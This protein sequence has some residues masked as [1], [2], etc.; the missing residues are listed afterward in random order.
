MKFAL[1]GTTI[2]LMSMTS[3]WAQLNWS[4]TYNYNSNTTI[5][6][7]IT[8]T[9]A[10]TVDVASGV[11]VTINGTISAPSGIYY[12]FTK[13]GAGSLI[14]NN[15]TSYYGTT[16]IES[17]T[18]ILGTNGTI[19]S[20][21]GV[22]FNSNTAK[23]DLSSGNKI[24]KG[25]NATSTASNA[26]V[27]IGSNTLTITTSYAD[28]SF[29]GKITGSG[30]IWKDSNGTLT[31]TGSNT[32]TGITHVEQGTLQIGDGVT[33]TTSIIDN[34]SKVAM[35]SSSGHFATI[36]FMPGAATTFSKVISGSNGSMQYEGSSTKTLTLSA[37]N[38]YTGSTTI[39]DG[40]LI[41]GTGGTIASN[42][43]ISFNSNTAK[44]DV[45]SGSKTIRALNAASTVSN[46]EVILGSSTLTIASTINNCSFA[47][48]IIGTGGI[49]KSGSYSLT[50]DGTNTYTGNTVIM[51]GGELIL[52]SNGS[53]S[54]SK[55]S[56]NGS[57]KILGNNTI[58]G[59]AGGGGTSAGVFINS[60]TLTINTT[61]DC[62]YSGPIT[63]TG[64]IIKTGNA[65][66]TLGG[67]STYTGTTTIEA[68]TLILSANGTIASDYGV[69]LNSNSAKLDV[70][71]GNKTIKGLNAASTVSNAEV[72]LGSS[73]L[74][75]QNSTNCSFAGKITG[76]GGITKTGNASLT[77]DGANCGTI[78]VNGGT[79]FLSGSSSISSVVNLSNTAKL[80]ISAGNK[81]IGGLNAT[82]SASSAEVILGSSTLTVS[83][84]SY[85]GK[86]IGTGGVT[87]NGTASFTMYN[88]GNTAT[89]TFT[90]NQ[91]TV[92]LN[93]CKW[94]GNFTTNTGVTLT[95]IGNSTVGPLTLANGTTLTVT[96][97]S[98]IG[99]LTLAG[100]TINFNLN[101][102]SPS[103]LAV[104][105]AVTATGT[106]TI[107][108]ATSVIQSGYTLISAASGITS[109]TPYVLASV[110]GYPSAE[111]FVNSPTLLRF[112]TASPPVITTTTL[113]NGTVGTPYYAQL[114]ATGTSPFF[115]YLSGGGWDPGL[116][117]STTGL[118]SGTP[119][120]AGTINFAVCA[121][122]SIGY[123]QAS[124]SIVIT[125]AAVAPTIT[126]TTLP[127][128]TIG[129]TY[130]QQLEATGTAS[131][132]WTLE[133][134]SLP[135][136]LTL[137]TTGEISGTPTTAGTFD[138][139][140]HASN[141]VG[142]DTKA[143]SITI[144]EPPTIT[145]TT[146]PDGVMGT[147]YNA[148]LAATGTT[149]ITW[150]IENG[151]LP[152]NLSLSTTG[153]ISGTPTATGTFNFTVKAINSAGSDTKALS[154]TI[155]TAAVAPIITT[156]T[157]PN[158]TEGTA[159]NQPL[160]ATGT[161]PITWTVSV[162][163]LP[164]GL[165]LSETGIISGT[166]TTAGTFN[167]TAKATNS[168]G[169]DTKAL[170]IT[171]NAVII[172][173]TITTTTLPDGITGTAYSKTLT[174]TGTTPINWAIANGN[175][176]T[177]L[178]LSTSGTISGTPTTTGTFNFT[179]KATNSAGNDTKALT[180]T[181]GT[182]AIA[183]IITT[184]TLPNGTEG[185]AYNQ[186]LT[187][188]G[189]A[190]ITWSLQ[191]GNLPAGLT[192]SAEGVITGTPTA[193]GTSNFTVKATNSA[194]SDTKVLSIKIESIVGIVETDNEPALRIYPNPTNGE[195]HIGYA[196]CDNA[197]CDIEIYD[198]YGRMLQTISRKSEIGK[199]EIKIDVSHLPSGIY[200][201]RVGN[202][203][204]K[205]VK[206]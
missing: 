97:N 64:G 78:T 179:V 127:N 182:T 77:L 102:S 153:I 6:E 172:P 166:P 139:V 162:G 174:A 107:K 202:R 115:W 103:K 68:G 155:G 181:I 86:F 123:D 193:A 180:I 114:T 95:I 145:T 15:A 167:F 75:I 144:L 55:V 118:I 23:L 195:L 51:S 52:D 169:N 173:P 11:T 81:T 117:L 14:L 177:G 45:S 83:N 91:G 100:S 164:T 116:T 38:T 87:K 2:M 25:L 61:S 28:C 111:L 17:G 21:Y 192:L 143:L 189:T 4:G 66:Q 165:S 141:S 159:Y 187:A 104:S 88:T 205:F 62:S 84:G 148:T 190:P 10:V 106:N 163:N 126:T 168:A 43:G 198:V 125:A 112:R 22:T 32:Y 57:L 5:S 137:T 184:T 171:I 36:K 7:N 73:T 133:S 157:L 47:G 40:T 63:G 20:L 59:L 33:P 30:G 135:T 158:G 24:I 186:P 110:T 13:S 130:N 56:V 146:L 39:I 12:T 50:L 140:A 16:I 90:H 124:L 76:T 113:P 92:T 48:K 18:I 37:S 151:N 89:G 27:I 108:V 35:S 41:L 94:A 99:S 9:G 93:A 46:A 156:T 74:T 44:L 134:G 53:I 136:G 65:S 194:G 69:S 204:A 147:A 85:Y 132:T 82:S 191:S 129:T 3:V 67:V 72:I 138:F 203:T 60:Y 26:E 70:S 8:L 154:I 96:G 128:G 19:F 199:S 150:S 101:G 161:A 176:P 29:A 197:I 1:L 185:T 152:T 188:T 79:L 34:T 149:P 170:S 109:L 71:A 183:P 121:E 42:N 131:I 178:T 98:T 80:D 105:G 58:G 31:L 54:S 120:T 196:M 160:T 49:T 201:L 206:N 119:T 200:F 122:N 142:S 175:L